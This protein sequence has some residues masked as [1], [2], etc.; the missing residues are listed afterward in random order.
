[1][2]FVDRAADVGSRADDREGSAGVAGVAGGCDG[3][4]VLMEP[5]AERLGA[6]GNRRGGPGSELV[7]DG[8]GG[9]LCAPSPASVHDRAYGAVGSVPRN[10]E[11]S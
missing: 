4:D 8:D 1:M 10:L 9:Q 2:E 3:A 6:D 5:A 7:V 11:P